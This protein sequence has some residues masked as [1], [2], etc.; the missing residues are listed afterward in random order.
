MLCCSFRLV[1]ATSH[2]IAD[3][4]VKYVVHA[5][6]SR[7]FYHTQKE[8]PPL[9]PSNRCRQPGLTAVAQFLERQGARSK[10]LTNRVN[11]NSGLAPK[12]QLTRA[13]DCAAESGSG[14]EREEDR[15]AGRFIPG[16]PQS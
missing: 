5:G 3:V 12:P 1:A 9:I 13:A 2:W 7:Y 4:G 10:T 11:F 14:P 6:A 16:Q 8:E 15:T